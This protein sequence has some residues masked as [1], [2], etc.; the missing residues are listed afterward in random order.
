MIRVTTPARLHFGLFV[1]EPEPTPWF[2]SDGEALPVRR[3]GGVGLMVRDPALV[4]R[5]EPASG[6]SATGP[7]AERA[8]RFAERVAEA[9]NHAG[10]PLALTIEQA[11]PAHAGLG[12]GT[13]LGL[14]VAKAVSLAWGRDATVADLARWSGRG[15]RSGIGVHG[16]AR[17]GFLIDGGKATPDGPSLLLGRYD[18]PDEWAIL[19]IRPPGHERMH[20]PAEVDAFA[21]L[22]ATSDVAGL[23]RLVLLGL[24]PALLER[25]L[26]TF[27]AALHEFNRKAGEAFAPVQGGPYA[28]PQIAG[29]VAELRAMG[30]H[31]VGQSSWGPTVFAVAERDRVAR[32]VAHLASR[33]VETVVT[34]AAP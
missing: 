1:P 10:P 21:R 29:L 12:S 17:G 31:G 11:M 24:L 30:L 32:L 20:G 26:A 7:L 15:L 34:S 3:F 14:A 9:L 5:A 22:P 28:S 2:A 27:G 18:F 19:L 16:F 23:S 6:W 13:Q 33:S 8:L 25:D 4:L